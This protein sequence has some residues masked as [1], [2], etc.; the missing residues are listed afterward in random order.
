M[1]DNI[2]ME[3]DLGDKL[4]YIISGDVFLIH[5]KSYTFVKELGVNGFFGEYAFFS[6]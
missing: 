5:R 4:Y 6:G 1:R 3:D 2:F